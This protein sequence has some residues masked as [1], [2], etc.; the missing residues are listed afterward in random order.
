MNDTPKSRLQLRGSFPARARAAWERD[1]RA[2]LGERTLAELHWRTDDFDLPPLLTREDVADLPHL[3][4][5]D[6]VSIPHRPAI[7][8]RVAAAT[9]QL[10]AAQ[11]RAALAHGVEELE[12]RLDAYATEGGAEEPALCA[13]PLANADDLCTALADVDLAHTPVCLEGDALI[14]LAFLLHA[15]QRRG[16]DPRALRGELGCEPMRSHGLDAAELVAARWTEADALLRWCTA[17]APGLRALCVDGRWCHE[18]GASAAAELACMVAATIEIARQ[19]RARGHAP[20]AVAHALV[21]HVAVGADLLQQAAKLRALRLLVAK[22]FAALVPAEEALPPP[23]LV[24]H[25]SERGCARRYDLHTNLVRGA[26]EAT[27][28]AIGG[29]DALWVAPYEPHPDYQDDEARA[30]VRYQ[31][32]LLR[33]EACLARTADPARGSYAVE[34]LTDALGRRA[35]TLVQEIEAAGGLPAAWN[36][37]VL[38]H[39][40]HSGSRRLSRVRRRAEV[41]VGVSRYVD[42]EL[43]ASRRRR[44]DRNEALRALHERM[45]AHAGQ[46]DAA[47][48]TLHADLEANGDAVLVTAVARAA[49][50]GCPAHALAD[51]LDEAH[52]RGDGDG[53]GD[54]ADLPATPQPEDVAPDL[55]LTDALDFEELRETVSEG[56]PPPRTIVLALTEHRTARVRADWAVDLLRAGGFAPIRPAPLPDAAAAAAAVA[57]HDAELVALCAADEALPELCAALE[58]TPCR[59]AL[60]ARPGAAATCAADVR[61]FDGGD[62]VMRLD[63]LQKLVELDRLERSRSASAVRRSLEDTLQELRAHIAREEQR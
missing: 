35:W 9:P 55:L 17:S 62:L 54:D 48:A 53:D 36:G 3:A 44:V 56:A 63:Y 11:I 42:P 61:L 5:V 16:V 2:A 40:L 26:L 20:A 28:A 13:L 4:A 21:F 25:G 33:S 10:A 57:A 8:E 7:R 39:V 49:A 32:H 46:H 58:S 59:T 6:A 43:E 30:L 51:V 47:L 22:V 45:A 1:V 52:F 37:F 27:A 50:A 38:R 60:V 34:A 24:G 14:G 19:M 41:L 12:L 31:H 18:F 15:A 23:V 29:C